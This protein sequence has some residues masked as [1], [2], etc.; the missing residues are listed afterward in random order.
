M[1]AEAARIDDEGAGA[2]VQ[3]AAIILKLRG[4]GISDRAV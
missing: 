3:A 1:S 4:I 2:Q